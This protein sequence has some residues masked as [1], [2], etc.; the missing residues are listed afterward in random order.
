MFL[1]CYTFGILYISSLLISISNLKLSHLVLKMVEYRATLTLVPTFAPRRTENFPGNFPSSGEAELLDEAEELARIKQIK[2]D[3]RELVFTPEKKTFQIGRA[4]S[5]PHKGLMA[6]RDNAFFLSP[7]M[8]RYHAE[9]HM[10]EKKKQIQIRDTD[11]M[12]GTYVNGKA[13]WGQEWQALNSGDALTFGAQVSREGEVFMPKD[14]TCDVIW[15]KIEFSPSTPEATN[16]KSDRRISGYGVS[17]EDLI[18]SD[19][20]TESVDFDKASIEYHCYSED[21]YS[22]DSEQ[23]DSDFEKENTDIMV[24]EDNFPTSSVRNEESKYGN[25]TKEQPTVDSAPLGV[26]LPSVKS[27]VPDTTP[28]RGKFSI[29]SLM[30]DTLEA[31]SSKRRVDGGDVEV[32]NTGSEVQVMEDKKDGPP[33]SSMDDK[34]SEG[35][36]AQPMVSGASSASSSTTSKLNKPAAP[37]L[38]IEV[39]SESDSDEAPE[40]LDVKDRGPWKHLSTPPTPPRETEKP[41]EKSSFNQP[42]NAPV[43]AKP[44]FQMATPSAAPPGPVAKS[45]P[46]NEV[47]PSDIFDVG[48]A[49]EWRKQG[50]PA[51]AT[52]PSGV[53]GFRGIASPPQ[54]DEF[55]AAMRDNQTTLANMM[56][57]ERWVRAPQPPVPFIPTASHEALEGLHP[58]P[59]PWVHGSFAPAHLTSPLQQP[60]VSTKS[61]NIHNTSTANQPTPQNARKPHL[62]EQLLLSD[63]AKA[64]TEKLEK[65][66]AAIYNHRGKR[67]VSFNPWTMEDDEPLEDS[68]FGDEDAD[69]ALD[70]AAHNLFA[71]RP[72]PVSVAD[73][74]IVHRM[75]KAKPRGFAISTLVDDQPA[76]AN[77]LKSARHWVAEKS[78]KEAQE[79]NEDSTMTDA[80]PPAE[81][82]VSTSSAKPREI[83]SHI[84]P[85]HGTK[86]KYDEAMYEDLTE[87]KVVQEPAPME[88]KIAEPLKEAPIVS[89]GVE[90]EGVSGEKE[91]VPL[92]LNEATGKAVA[93]AETPRQEELQQPPPKR[94]RIFTTGFALG[95]VTGAVGLFAALVAS[96]P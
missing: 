33:K 96:A 16:N 78:P 41:L 65:L 9:V 54:K 7:V 19:D 55:F 39:D 38:F 56:M 53:C 75:E 50:A 89:V 95:A 37:T 68:P 79:N 93:A 82:S 59:L 8:S 24:V 49:D 42:I 51:L 18:I 23:D 2:E 34:S 74:Y 70:E 64:R 29:G 94:A 84:S 45:C 60:N 46:T 77:A 27:L 36:Q 92:V 14:F 58:A 52:A 31:L 80:A 71:A 6:A 90:M 13:I 86:R 76:T 40:E 88:E 44:V 73:P 83:L 63:E 15:E 66:K 20:D 61:S 25:K 10:I 81:V 4:S 47:K 69:M 62:F 32:A 17:S 35:Q 5:N 12:H 11:S 72:R 22:D 57:R 3:T 30:N 48:K 28:A 87:D 91:A 21:E 85:P 43:P 1:V 26:R 67:D